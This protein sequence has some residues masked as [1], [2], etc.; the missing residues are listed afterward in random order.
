MVTLR[1]PSPDNGL[2]PLTPGSRWKP[3]EPVTSCQLRQQGQGLGVPLDHLQ[4]LVSPCPDHVTVPVPCDHSRITITDY[5]A[6]HHDLSALL[7]LLPTTLSFILSLLFSQHLSEFFAGNI[8]SINSTFPAIHLSKSYTPVTATLI[9]NI[10]AISPIR[11]H[12]HLEEIRKR[13][14]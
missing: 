7:R 1:L 4:G 13:P 5:G 8:A 9:F 6:G 2:H 14:G 11:A 12:R 10:I 3:L